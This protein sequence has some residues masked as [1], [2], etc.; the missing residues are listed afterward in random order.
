LP[1]QI[2]LVLDSCCDFVRCSLA[3]RRGSCILLEVLQQSL[4]CVCVCFHGEVLCVRYGQWCSRSQICFVASF[5][6]RWL[7][8]FLLC[9]QLFWFHGGP[10]NADTKSMKLNAALRGEIILYVSGVMRRLLLGVCFVNS[11][12]L[13]AVLYLWLSVVL[14]ISRPREHTNARRCS[15]QVGWLLL[16]SL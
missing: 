15:H 12:G 4:A 9:L 14:F 2:L 3:A 7:L 6:Q 8:S 5:R 13:C 16:L 1:P 10:S 11:D